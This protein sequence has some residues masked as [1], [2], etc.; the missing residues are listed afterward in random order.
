M[1][2]QQQPITSGGSKIKTSPEEQLAQP[3]K[4]SRPSGSNSLFIITAVSFAA[5]TC[6]A[7]YYHRSPNAT[8]LWALIVLFWFS[9]A[10]VQF[11]A[12]SFLYVAY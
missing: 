9:L 5:I 11:L 3:A 12:L 2:D 8:H 1:V 7:F 6:L 4:Q 10:L